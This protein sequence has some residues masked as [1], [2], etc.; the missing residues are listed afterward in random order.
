LTLRMNIRSLY[1]AINGMARKQDWNWVRHH[2]ALPREAAVQAGRK[3]IVPPDPVA[4][5]L[6]ALDYCDAMDR[7]PPGRRVDNSVRFRDGLLA[8][9]GVYFAIRHKNL[10]EI[11]IS[12]HLIIGEDDVSRLVFDDPLKNDE[13]I[14]SLVPDVLR[15]YIQR[16]LAH[17]RKI[18]AITLTCRSF[19][20]M[21]RVGPW[22]IPA[23][24]SCSSG[25]V[26]G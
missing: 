5:L 23:C 11:L 20:S 3:R 8:A 24:F 7:L 1:H 12:R 21:R 14:D 19:G 15:P 26:S 4:L 25:W 18:C 22:V 10:W 13:R 2:R 6:G 9:M 17:H 16:Y